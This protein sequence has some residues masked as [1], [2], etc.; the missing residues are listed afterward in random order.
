MTRVLSAAVIVVA[1]ILLCGHGV[2]AAD[3]VPFVNVPV[4][5][6][7]PPTDEFQ[8]PSVAVDPLHP[9][10]VAIAYHAPNQ[11]QPYGAPG[12]RC[13]LATSTDAG[14]TWSARIVVGKGGQQPLPNGGTC[15]WTTLA[16]TPTGGLAYL[17]EEESSGAAS[18]RFGLM[19]SPSISG[20]LAPP[21][22]VDT[23]PPGGAIYLDGDWAEPS[24]A[25]DP[26]T[27][28]GPARIY[29][30]WQ[31]W[32]GAP[33]PHGFAAVSEDG[34]RS[35]AP[36]TSFTPA[37]EKGSAAPGRPVAAAVDPTG[38]LSVA[39][40]QAGV[41]DS[42]SVIPYT[43]EVVRS[44]DHGQTFS[45]PL[46]LGKLPG[47]C[48]IL[49]GMYC[50]NLDGA[51]ISLAAG[52][53]PGRLVLAYSGPAG[54]V[55]CEGVAAQLPAGCPGDRI[56]ETHSVDGGST[57]S[58]GRQIGIPAGRESDKQI[59]PT[60]RSAPG[61]RVDVA[62][63]GFNPATGFEDTYVV[64]SADGASTFGTARR[65]SSVSSD[66]AIGPPLFGG[67]AGGDYYSHFGNGLYDF[68]GLASTNAGP[69]VAWTDSRRGTT[70][71]HHVDIYVAPAAS[72]PG[73]ETGPA[74]RG[75]AAFGP[76][77]PSTAESGSQPS[78]VALTAA[79]AAAVAAV[80]WR[81][82]R[83]DASHSSLPE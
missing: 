13:Y 6:L 80:R 26:A 25:V 50:N 34:G 23:V 69:L 9:S 83:A 68:L 67:G 22:D 32:T 4:T 29:V 71:T 43:V 36:R 7:N 11:E 37:G 21:V 51:S 53:A 33:V 10:H 76:S 79:A 81:R 56:T 20:A 31:V 47:E 78:L 59:R 30:A 55:S 39:Y 27:G 48:L 2:T 19:V 49:T 58:P 45:A 54:T 40:L 14:I 1:T 52:P 5:P 74:S 72:A 57:W 60:V 44:T 18:T 63:Y 12:D 75:G 17:F 70:A 35:F 38:V 61:G 24:L 15:N 64:S 65:V 41:P 66:T 46:M 42:N 16:F 82:R 3:R 62:Y 73:T 77:L 28:S 8:D